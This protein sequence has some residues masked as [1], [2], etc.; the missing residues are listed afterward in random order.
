M[1]IGY[2]PAPLR[3]GSAEVHSTGAAP[4]P[5]PN[6]EIIGASIGPPHR[7]NLVSNNS[8]SKHPARS[9]YRALQPLSVMTI[10]ADLR[11]AGRMPSSL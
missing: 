2:L 8:E 9:R 7:A 4:T 11:G 1:L 10:A 6:A 5:L 3:V